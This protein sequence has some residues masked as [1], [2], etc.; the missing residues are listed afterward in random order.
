MMFSENMDGMLGEGSL[1]SDQ[2]AMRLH[3]NMRMRRSV[4]QAKLLLLI[5]QNVPRNTLVAQLFWQ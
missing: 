3:T 1:I 2:I 4:P 5:A